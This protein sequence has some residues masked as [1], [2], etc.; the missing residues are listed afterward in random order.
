MRIGILLGTL[1]PTKVDASLFPNSTQQ[2][3]VN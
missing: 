3:E 1:Y 2:V